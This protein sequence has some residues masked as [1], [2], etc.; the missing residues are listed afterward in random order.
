MKKSNLLILIL[1]LIFSVASLSACKEDE[2]T[3]VVGASSTPH[4][5]ILAAAKPLLEEKG[6]TLKIEV[7][8]DYVMPNTTLQS[9]DLDANYFQHLPYLNSFNASKKTDLVSVGPV[10]YEPFG[11]YGKGITDLSNVPSGTVIFIPNDD[12]NLTRALLLLAQENLIEI[13]S[14]KNATTGVDLKDVTDNKGYELKAVDA[15]LVP[16][17]YKNN[18]NILAVINGNYALSAN[19]SIS[20]ALAVEDAA[21]DAATTYANII[22]V[23]A[24][25]ETNPKIVAL[26]EV[27]TSQTIKDYITNTYNGAVLPL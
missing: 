17:Q 26:Y 21:G 18:N 5:E 27:L 24:G 6:Y 20:T 9:G 23:K 2:N 22:A 13:D 7:F 3:I 4:A 11:L 10:H 1:T 25:N 12:S 14:S 15:G 19:I 16:A 8:D